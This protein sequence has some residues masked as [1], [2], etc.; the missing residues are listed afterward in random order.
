M[1]RFDTSR[2]LIKWGNAALLEAEKSIEGFFSDNHGVA[3]LIEADPATGEQVFKVKLIRPVPSIFA[4]K[5]TEAI[6][7]ARN[8][9][10]QTLFAACSVINIPIKDAHYPWASDLVDLRKWKLEGKDPGR[11]KIPRD[12]WDIIIAHEP[13]RRTDGHAAG[14][15]IIRSMAQ[16]ANRK[17]TIGVTV[18]AEV[19]SVASGINKIIKKNG[20][21]SLMV[22]C[23]DPVNNEIELIRWTGPKP[24]LDVNYTLKFC[25]G[26]DAA[27]PIGGMPAVNPVRAFLIKAQ[28]VLDSFEARCAEILE[29]RQHGVAPSASENTKSTEL[30]S[31][32]WRDNPLS[33]WVREV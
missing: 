4:R 28:I 33:G 19:G 7:N 3:S 25:V 17:H 20:T 18:G 11:P 5:I 29:A 23:W 1:G 31:L 15:D 26:L 30:A 16:F 27:P 22:P 24:H 12:F 10:D 21:M 6:N 13:Y 9:F 2:E 14:D 8:A 32:N